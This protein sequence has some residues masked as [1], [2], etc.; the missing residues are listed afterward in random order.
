[1]TAPARRSGVVFDLDGVL[2]MTEHLWDEAW[3]FYAAQYAYVWT[4]DDTRAC[5]GMSVVEWAAY[6]AIR[7]SGDTADAARRV[8]DRVADAYATGR[9]TLAPGAEELIVGVAG[10]VPIGLASS[11][12]REII[13]MVMATMDIGRYFSATVSSAEVGHG[14]PS[15]DVYREVVDRLGVDPA[16]SLAV[17]DSSNGVRAAAAAGLR[18]I[19]IPHEGYPLAP[20]ARDLAASVQLSLAG[21]RDE[22]MRILDG[23]PSGGLRA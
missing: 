19:A 15:P 14:K 20:D 23:H 22:I 16:A 6:L 13:D 3:R 18:V 9:V 5:Q 21:V 17:E 10:R 4:D 12:P 8:I 2:V 11:A 7:S 1:M